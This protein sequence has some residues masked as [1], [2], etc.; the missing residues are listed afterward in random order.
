MKNAIVVIGGGFGD[1][2]KGLFT[3]YLSAQC[4]G[5]ACVVRFN[6]GAQAGHTVQL[7]DGRRHVFSHF[8]SGTYAGLP[9]Y[10]SSFF[11]CNPILFHREYGELIKE[12]V[13][14]DVY[15]DP[16]CPVTTPYDMMINQIAEQARG[17]ERHGSVGVGFGETIGR[18]YHK[19]FLLFARDLA[20]E[21][22]LRAK[23]GAIRSVWVRRRLAALGVTP[24]VGMWADR[25]IDDGI[26]ERFIEDCR[27]FSEKIVL[28]DLPMLG[29][30]DDLIFEGAQGLMLDQNNGFYPHV[31]RSHTGIRNA[32][33]LAEKIGMEKLDVYYLTR[34]YVTRHG[35]GPLPHELP[36]QPYRQIVDKTNIA[37]P[38]QG[39]LRFAWLDLDLFCEAAARDMKANRSRIE[40]CPHLGI[41]CLDQIDSDATYISNG[42]RKSCSGEGLVEAARQGIGAATALASWGPSRATIQKTK[43][44]SGFWRINGVFKAFDVEQADRL[45]AVS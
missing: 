16:A 15:V 30:Y 3:D 4:V 41:S 45:V 44:C 8:G 17:G 31:T 7:A 19:A 27:D 22:T 6:G 34:S 9:T 20:D 24:L 5:K 36:Q 21:Q 1:E 33:T 32:V 29:G 40:V 26:F 42:E 13:K 18:H 25:F 10:L 28:S 43:A 11:V 14:P 37:H 12:G 2:G 23:L 39:T 35:A 38:Y